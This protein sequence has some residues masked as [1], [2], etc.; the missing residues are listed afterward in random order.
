[1]GILVAI[2]GGGTDLFLFVAGKLFY[3]GEMVDN[4]RFEFCGPFYD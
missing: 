1:M 3:D 4:F 2:H